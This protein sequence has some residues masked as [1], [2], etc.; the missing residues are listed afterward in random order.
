MIKTIFGWLGLKGGQV[1]SWTG[2]K[3]RQKPNL[4]KCGKTNLKVEREI[5]KKLFLILLISFFSL[6]PFFKLIFLLSFTKHKKMRIKSIKYK[7]TSK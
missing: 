1:D 5:K 3:L 2:S 4:K 7:K 6:Q